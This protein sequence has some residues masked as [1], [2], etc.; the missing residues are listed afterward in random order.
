[1]QLQ[2]G[3]VVSVMINQK[4]VMLA[5]SKTGNQKPKAESVRPV[6]YAVPLLESHAPPRTLERL[7]II[8]QQDGVEALSLHS[9]RA[10]AAFWQLCGHELGGGLQ[11]VFN[12]ES[13][14]DR[15]W[16]E[17]QLRT[18]SNIGHQALLLAADVQRGHEQAAF[19]G[20]GRRSSLEG[21]SSGFCD[22][23]LDQMLE[24]LTA[25]FLRPPKCEEPSMHALKNVWVE[26]KRLL[27]R[28]GVQNQLEMDAHRDQ[29]R[30]NS[31]DES[32]EEKTV[33]KIDLFVK[34]LVLGAVKDVAEAILSARPVLAT[35]AG[36][37]SL[38]Q[39]LVLPSLHKLREHA[40][41]STRVLVAHTHLDATF[42]DVMLAVANGAVRSNPGTNLTA[43]AADSRDDDAKVLCTLS[44]QRHGALPSAQELRSRAVLFADLR[45]ARVQR[46]LPYSDLDHYMNVYCQ[47]FRAEAFAPL[48]EA[49]ET[50]L[51]VEKH[52][53][54]EKE[55]RRGGAMG[56]LANQEPIKKLKFGETRTYS[57]CF[58]GLYPLASGPQKG[59]LGLAFRAKP[60]DELY[61]D[62]FGKGGYDWARCGLAQG[63]LLAMSACGDF[64]SR[65]SLLYLTVELRDET[66]LRERGLF[67]AVPIVDR[68]SALPPGESVCACVRKVM[69]CASRLRLVESPGFFPAMGPALAAL[70]SRSTVP[71]SDTLVHCKPSIKDQP[72]YDLDARFPKNLVLKVKVSDG[73]KGFESVA[74]LSTTR[75]PDETCSIREFLSDVEDPHSDLRVRSELHLEQL[76]ALAY[77]LTTPLSVIQGAPGTGKSFIA[78]RATLIVRAVE[79]HRPCRILT[80][81]YKNHAT[82]EFA[83]DI[84]DAGLKI[85]RVGG[86]C[87]DP[88]LQQYN[89][90]AL[91]R[92]EAYRNRTNEGSK[93][94][95]RYVC[96]VREEREQ[97]DKSLEDMRMKLKQKE[98]PVTLEASVL[99]QV[100]TLQTAIHF[101]EQWAKNALAAPAQIRQGFM[102]V[103]G[104]KSKSKPRGKKLA[105][106]KRRRAH[107][108]QEIYLPALKALCNIFRLKGWKLPSFTQ[109][110]RIC[111]GTDQVSGLPEMRREISRM[112]NH[113]GPDLINIFQHHALSDWLPP[114]RQH[115]E[116]LDRVR[117]PVLFDSISADSKMG[118]GPDLFAGGSGEVGANE[119]GYE[120]VLTD[121]ERE[122]DRYE[123]VREQYVEHLFS[124]DQKKPLVHE[125]RVKP[126]AIARLRFD[127]ESGSSSSGKSRAQVRTQNDLELIPEIANSLGS[128]ND[129]TKKEELLRQA[130][131]WQLGADDRCRFVHMAL[132]KHAS[133]RD[134]LLK[135]LEVELGQLSDRHRVTEEL[136]KVA[137]LTPHCGNIGIRPEQPVVA[138]TIDGA[139]IQSRL[140]QKCGFSTVFIEE[141]CELL[142]SKLCA[143]MPASTRHLVLIGDPLQLPPNPE[144]FELK[145]HFDFA[146]SVMERLIANGYEYRTLMRQSRMHAQIAWLSRHTYPSM[147][148]HKTVT[149][150]LQLFRGLKSPVFFWDT[151]SDYGEIQTTSV[152]NQE[153]AL[154][155]VCLVQY[156]LYHGVSP[157]CIAVLA[158]YKGQ[159]RLIRSLGRESEKYGVE[160]FLGQRFQRTASVGEL[161]Q[162]GRNPLQKPNASGPGSFVQSYSDEEKQIL[163]TYPA[164]DDVTVDSVDNFQG[165]QK[166]F[167]IVSF[168]RSNPEHRCG[169]LK[170]EEGRQRLN[171]A[172]TRPRRC[173][174][175]VGDRSCLQFD[176]RRGDK[177]RQTGLRLQDR[178]E[179]FPN[180]IFQNLFRDLDE[181]GWVGRSVPVACMNHPEDQSLVCEDADAWRLGRFQCKKVCNRSRVCGHLCRRRCHP[182]KCE[183]IGC[184]DR[185]QLTCNRDM[186]H[187]PWNAECYE[188]KAAK[189]PVQVDFRCA[190]CCNPDLF[191]ELKDLEKMNSSASNEYERRKSALLRHTTLTRACW[192]EETSVRCV[193][194]FDYWCANGDH[195]SSRSCHE[196]ESSKCLKPTSRLR[197]CGHKFELFCHQV[198]T[199]DP[200]LEEFLRSQP[201]CQQFVSEQCNRCGRGE[202][203][204]RCS[205]QQ[206]VDVCPLKVPHRCGT[207]HQMTERQCVQ[208]AEDYDCPAV[209]IEHCQR[210][211]VGTTQRHCF[212]GRLLREC[213]QE[214]DVVCSRCDTSAK[215]KCTTPLSEHRCQALL[216]EVCPRCGVEGSR[217]CFDPELVCSTM[218]DLKCDSCGSVLGK[219]ACGK[220]PSPIEFDEKF[221]CTSLV[222]HMCAKCGD[223]DRKQCALPAA[224]HVCQRPCKQTLSFCG[225]ICSRKCGMPCPRDETECRL[226]AL[227]K[228]RQWL[229]YGCRDFRHELHPL[230]RVGERILMPVWQLEFTQ[231]S[232]SR[233]MRSGVSVDACA[234]EL[235]SRTPEDLH[236]DSFE[237]KFANLMVY[238]WSTPPDDCGQET[239][240]FMSLDNRRLCLLK[241]CVPGGKVWVTLSDNFKDFVA[242]YEPRKRRRQE[243]DEIRQVDGVGR[244]D[245][246][247]DLRHRERRDQRQSETREERKARRRERFLA[248][249]RGAAQETEVAGE[250]IALTVAERRHHESEHRDLRKLHRKEEKQQKERHDQHGMA[251]DPPADCLKQTTAVARESEQETERFP[252]SGVRPLA[253]AHLPAAPSTAPTAPLAPS[254]PTATSDLLKE[255]IP[256]GVPLHAPFRWCRGEAAGSRHSSVVRFTSFARGDFLVCCTDGSQL[257]RRL[258]LEPANSMLSVEGKVAPPAPLRPEDDLYDPKVFLALEASAHRAVTHQADCSERPDLSCAPALRPGI[259]DGSAVPGIIG[260][261]LMTPEAEAHERDNQRDLYRGSLLLNL[262]RLRVGLCK[263]RRT[264][265]VAELLNNFTMLHHQNMSSVY[266]GFRFLGYRDSSSGNVFLWPV[267]Q[268]LLPGQDRRSSVDAND[269]KERRFRQA[270]CG[271]ELDDP[272]T[273]VHLLP[274]GLAHAFPLAADTD[275]R[276]KGKGFKGHGRETGSQSALPPAFV[277]FGCK[278]YA[279]DTVSGKQFRTRCQRS[280]RK[281]EEAAASDF[282]D[283]QLMRTMLQ[284]GHPYKRYSEMACHGSG[285]VLLGFHGSGKEA[286]LEHMCMI[287][288][289]ASFRERFHFSLEKDVLLAGNLLG[290]LFEWLGEVLLQ[291]SDAV[292]AFQRTADNREEMQEEV[293]GKDKAKGDEK[294]KGK[295]KGKPGGQLHAREVEL[296]VRQAILGEDY[297]A[298]LMTEIKKHCE[299][300]LR[301]HV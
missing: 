133:I 124:S 301:Q 76:Q 273:A 200:H 34:T 216:P 142:E 134:T 188:T 71:L 4:S 114:V 250:S 100:L 210:C 85:V 207:C 113:H 171:V 218:V 23:P 160:K 278:A 204:R 224:E 291:N 47:L 117:G 39:L 28:E 81:S 228:T 289:L 213:E 52:L 141:A 82:D 163:I 174:L 75:P 16:R 249:V 187:P 67:V 290:S 282:R 276:S 176:F 146:T 238:M 173:L 1:M 84:L 36:N 74:G 251:E 166:E 192:Q 25:V 223:T 97:F 209:L 197:D 43:M 125:M 190:R 137:I 300:G 22:K 270:L 59:K 31:K 93:K 211:G 295:G 221:V 138:M 220:P 205:E 122:A 17:Q 240:R 232:C 101:L 283:K 92:D 247:N 185:V 51:T 149:D 242:K 65:N 111:C 131:L 280:S 193:E 172:I 129:S 169:F 284:F 264:F 128:S 260:Q 102:E 57:A 244:E 109:V 68:N 255:E 54:L 20:G 191:R 96:Q 103:G 252:S 77:I 217:R 292:V 198:N 158:M 262:R 94:H 277:V 104:G 181:K 90:Q 288:S 177:D 167:I 118:G 66:Q 201:K 203:R 275:Q 257:S 64:S 298:E 121:E 27:A 63:T 70:T 180:Q 271:G 55:R 183:V 208:P 296:H 233:E 35:A 293:K 136:R 139:C 189:C 11:A 178:S 147:E 12:E 13:R 110:I 258:A 56:S 243:P 215:R 86:R 88:Q 61:A 241:K 108:A 165:N 91:L 45:D 175:L 112:L 253:A 40:A 145:E 79:A 95:P 267:F 222:N 29:A 299:Q 41:S 269:F 153:E 26:R 21:V 14:A 33:R 159:V 105:Q 148:C 227:E 164:F 115:F 73:R 151:G 135:N 236:P 38:L 49:V 157:D 87:S 30:G 279:I 80:L 62:S 202:L 83:V 254:S 143:C 19:G 44:W 266:P 261:E 268:E 53:N 24:T 194:R 89:L 144:V 130:D 225:H 186:S 99:G 246:A 10:G 5:K 8:A 206:P 259:L 154:R 32:E 150:G 195:K 132:E 155:C 127:Y 156:L 184:T 170:R 46:N 50:V 48:C 281:V 106:E 107:H 42:T 285:G 256:T 214:F 287:P 123:L 3:D 179:K 231:G 119:N 98:Q 229:E 234:D 168:V 294:G 72:L 274:Q 219:H 152:Q 263:E 69:R 196:D 226:C 78:V 237:R 6:K 2:K 272:A 239:T 120:D 248:D 161:L 126:E 182:D 286:Q 116:L 245:R 37:T 7:K 60:E 230:Y 297:S 199:N 265:V 140:V 212:E 162:K 18:L 235:M 58:E 15:R 9:Q